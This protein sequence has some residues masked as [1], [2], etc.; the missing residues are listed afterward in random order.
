[1]KRVSVENQE[2]QIKSRFNW[3]LWKEEVVLSKPKEQFDIEGLREKYSDFNTE[4]REAIQKSNAFA[5]SKCKAIVSGQKV[6]MLASLP[7]EKHSTTFNWNGWINAGLKALK[8][9]S[10]QT[11]NTIINE[12]INIGSQLPEEDQQFYAECIEHFL[13]KGLKNLFNGFYSDLAY[14]LKEIKQVNIGSE[15]INQ[16]AVGQQKRVVEFFY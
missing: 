16:W 7:H 5:K 4:S 6:H 12:V 3:S 15:Q 10:D 11:H 1:M 2:I 14:E 8:K 9:R 13:L